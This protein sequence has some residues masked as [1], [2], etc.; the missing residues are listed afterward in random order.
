[1]PFFTPDV[2]D[3][4][5]RIDLLTYLQTYEPQELVHFS[6]HT[7]CTKTHDSLKISNGKWCW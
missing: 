3:Q 5:R 6:G 7:Y 2:V 1:M 4:V